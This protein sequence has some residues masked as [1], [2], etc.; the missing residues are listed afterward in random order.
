MKIISFAASCA[1]LTHLSI[2]VIIFFNFQSLLRPLGVTLSSFEVLPE[3]LILVE[4]FQVNYCT[5][6]DPV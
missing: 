1:E 6:Q 3:T 4:A 2:Q 5:L